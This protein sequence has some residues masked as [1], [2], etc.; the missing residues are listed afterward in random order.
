[1]QG[2]DQPLPIDLDDPV[3]VDRLLELNNAHATELS[4]LDGPEFRHLVDE[5]FYACRIGDADAF[6]LTFDQT[7]SYD[8][9]NFLWFRERY[10]RFTYVDRICVAPTARGRGLARRL[11]DALFERAR[12]AGHDVIVC[13][14][15]IDPPNPGSDA[16]H[17]ALGFVEVG[18]AAIYDGAKTVRYLARAL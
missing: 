5:T 12:D 11:Y 1:M 3:L 17:A 16:F 7:A 9:P 18:R 14:V 15:N 6:M 2:K 10:P 13:E 4:L 8:S